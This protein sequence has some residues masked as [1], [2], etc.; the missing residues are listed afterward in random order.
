MGK[1]RSKNLRSELKKKGLSNLGSDEK[2]DGSERTEQE[3]RK[4]DRG[5]VGG[6]K[7]E[8]GREG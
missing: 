4:R 8:R 1:K 7:T 5:G 2:M 3:L 6:G